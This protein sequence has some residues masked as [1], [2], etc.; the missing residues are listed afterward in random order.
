M[1][2]LLAAMLDAI[3]NFSMKNLVPDMAHRPNTLAVVSYPYLSMEG[4][5]DN[6]FALIV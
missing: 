4:W 1:L 6:K 2:S 5:N 3:L